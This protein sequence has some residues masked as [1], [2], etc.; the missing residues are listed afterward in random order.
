[1]NTTTRMSQ[2]NQVDEVLRETE[3]GTF[4]F[5]H[6]ILVIFFFGAIV[7]GVF[8]YGIFSHFQSKRYAKYGNELFIFSQNE[9]LQFEKKKLSVSALVK[10]YEEITSTMGSYPGLAYQ[11]LRVADLLIKQGAF[12]QAQGILEKGFQIFTRPYMRYFYATRLAVLYEDQGEYDKAI[13]CLQGLLS[14]PARFLEGKIYLDLGRL[15]QLKGDK[16]KAKASFEWVVEKASEEEFRKMA[17][18]YLSGL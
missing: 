12:T 1:M 2:A 8:G 9:L 13:E 6:K 14:G 16:A 7:L 17:K 5:R 11:N 4:I 10:K 18:L 15:Q 3:L